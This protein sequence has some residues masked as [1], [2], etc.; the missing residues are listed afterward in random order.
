MVSAIPVQW[1]NL[2]KNSENISDPC[3]HLNYLTRRIPIE[4]LTSKLIYGMLIHKIKEKSSSE[5]TIQNKIN[6]QN[7][8]WPYIYN[9]A[10]QTSIDSYSRTFQFKC[11]HNILFLNE[12]LFKL[13][14]SDTPL[15][16]YCNT[17]PENMIHLFSEC[18]LTKEL[19]R[20]VRTSLPDVQLTELT[21]G[22]AYLGL[23]PLDDILA[24]HIHLIFKIAIY[25]SRKKRS[26][27]FNIL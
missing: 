20:Q 27:Q 2:V 12:R 25:N 6:D 23:N 3:Y 13:N 14:H 1:K 16:S 17:S 21:P 9:F 15:C 10:W 18:H 7:I 24:N 26:V 11:M 5:L 8:N 22:S 19:W 4:N